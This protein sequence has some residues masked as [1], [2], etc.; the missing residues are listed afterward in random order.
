MAKQFW[1]KASQSIQ[2]SAQRR[3]AAAAAAAAAAAT[4]AAA[5]AAPGIS[6]HLQQLRA[7]SQSGWSKFCVAYLLRASVLA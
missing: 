5:A 1:T 2:P 4:A 6:R 7:N 3:G